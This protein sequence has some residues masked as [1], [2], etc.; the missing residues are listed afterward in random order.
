M[1]AF[2]PG[3]GADVLV[4]Y[5]AEQ[6]RPVAKRTVIV[7]N[8][9]GAGG[10]IAVEYVARSKPDGYT[11]FVH[12]ASSVASL[13]RLYKNPPVDVGKAIQVAATINRQ[14][15]MTVV[16]AKS[17]YQTLAE[18]TAAMKLKGDKASYAASA[19]NGRIMDE[20]YKVATGVAAVEVNYRSA[21]ESLNDLMSGAVDFGMQDPVFST[22]Q[23][24]EN[25]LRI[26]A[27]SSG[28]RLQDNPEFPTMRE[29][30]AP[31]DLTGWW[32]SWC[33]AGRRSR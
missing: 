18:L 29:L 17:P 15:F 27:V 3:S 9:V 23:S 21:P 19:P 14:P 2:P 22:A 12:A 30:G 13:M 4:R 20:L 25:L 16:S 11:V 31:M 7:E 10:N 33:R 32:L 1:C 6:L 5:F 28:D 26:L 24:R 8:R